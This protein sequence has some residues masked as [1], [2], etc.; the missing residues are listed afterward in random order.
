[1]Q[2]I[3]LSPY[4]DRFNPDQDR[5]KVLYQPD[6]PLQQSELIES[7]SIIEYYLGTMGDSI[8]SDGN[9]QSGMD[10]VLQG[11]QL[12]IKD[13]QLYLGGKVRNF[14]QQV[15]TIKG[16]GRELVGVKLAQNIITSDDDPILL[17]QTAGV[18]SSFSKGADRL[19]EKVKLVLDDPEGA[20]V[21][22]FQDGELFTSTENPEMTKINDILAERTYDESG[23]YRVYGFDLWAG[24]K[25]ADT[26][27]VQVV[28]DAGRAY[29]IGYKVDKPV[30]SRI[31]LDKATDTREVQ[32]EGFFYLDAKRS[33][34]LGNA[35]VSSV[36]KVVGQVMVVK[37]QVSRGVQGGG[38]DF[39]KNGSVFQIDRVWSEGAGAKEYTQ[40]VDFQL[41][42]GQ[43]VSWAPE[44]AEPPAGS[45]YFVTYRY[46]KTLVENVDYK[47]IMSG[48]GDSTTCTIDFNGMSGS[49]PIDNTLVN[50]DYTFYLARKDLLVLDRQGNITVH[51]G[52]PE[53]MR[54]VEA[55]NHID[56][57]TLQLGTVTIYPNSDTMSTNLFT[58]TRL[59]MEDLQKLKIRVDNI[60]YNEAV[61]MLDNPAMAG[62][63]PIYLRGVFSDGFISLDKYDSSHPDAKIAFSFEDAE[64]TLPY[65]EV[66]K[67]VPQILENAS[68][69]NVWG[70]LV[71]APFTEEVAISQ[72]FATEAMNVN[73]YNMFNKQG[74]L[75]LTPSADNWIEEE[76]V[77]ITKEEVASF[78]SHRWW[79]HGGQFNSAQDQWYA[80]NFQPDDGKWLN[81]AQGETMSGTTLSSG[82]TQTLDTAIEFMRQIDIAFDAQNLH[83][84]AN[85]LYLTFDGIRVPITP[86]AGF[87]KGSDAGTIQA[88]SS[89]VA[90]GKF[91]I[92]A[93]IR[94]GIREVTLRNPDNTASNSFTAQ[95]RKKTVQDIIIRT[96]VTIV[97]IDPLAQSFQF[98]ENKVITS[99]G[100]YFSTKDTSENVIVQ[101]RG[102]SDG[103][104]PNK[105]IY[106]ETVLKPSQVKTSAD[107]TL[108]TK[109][110]FDD[111]IMCTAGQEYCIVIITDS[112]QYNMWIATRGRP[113]IDNPSVLVNGNP[114]LT[115]VLYSSSNASAWTAHQDSDLKFNVYTAKFNEEAVIEFDT[116]KNVQV[117][118]IVLMSTY[119]TPQNTGCR[120]EMKM[121]LANEAS[122]VTVAQKEWQPIGNYIDLDV[123]Q[124]AREVK[125]KATFKANK[126]ISPLLSL[127]DIMFVGFL[128]ALEGS[129]VARTIDLTDAPYNTLKISYETFLPA[130]TTVTPRYSID[131]GT[132]WKTLTVTPKVT[133]QTE[134]F[135][136][137]E[138]EEKITTG[139]ATNKTIKWRLDL[140]SQNSFLRPRVRRLMTLMKNV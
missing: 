23:S 76:R 124:L 115:G 6:R 44:G 122:N 56:P 127:D 63:N 40:G 46:N 14:E 132:T 86:D 4:F 129:Y 30:S 55:P 136:K 59:S 113:R 43:S 139:T 21:Y 77:T 109:V 107:A 31:A 16:V 105:T 135:N 89:G 84:N 11:K 100:L 82:G 74:L 28:V 66:N 80:N 106:A 111:P 94:C 78:T 75:T 7:Q 67:V 88:N 20:T 112:D 64:I 61:N 92:P 41:S 26:T 3:K 121:V 97:L 65:E 81:T 119:L 95:G 133:Q 49:K 34:V 102:M 29:V 71:S 17:D 96:R 52:Q 42:A 98:D 117:D 54:N 70:R 51:K 72:P 37:E 68:E 36:N 131:E 32:N 120:W 15:I 18:P 62:E 22:V 128:T 116:M 99:F 1:M 57:L 2:D 9:L 58:I 138:Y 53:T 10:F 91:T 60:E 108:E 73:P 126:Y 8:F 83:P 110:S 27:K 19:E 104:Q 47:V 25:L 140:K 114:Y 50:V 5:T 125:L 69:A 137:Y 87:L 24:E 93:N 39:L 101:V 38:T 134:N 123:L 48:T 130:N 33:G 45:T 12:T 79:L 85:N 90:K 103:G 118:R 13:G 35:P